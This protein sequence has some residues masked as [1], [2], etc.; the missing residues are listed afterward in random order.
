MPV[1]KTHVSKIGAL[2]ITDSWPIWSM[3]GPPCSAGRLSACCARFIRWR[4]RRYGQRNRRRTSNC[5]KHRRSEHA[6][7]PL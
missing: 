3:A 2:T 4:R 6:W 5:E 1:E 7:S